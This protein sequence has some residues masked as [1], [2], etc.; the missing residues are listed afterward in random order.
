VI[1]I[2]LYLYKA[3]IDLWFAIISSKRSAQLDDS[4]FVE[5][6]TRYPVRASSQ[7]P[8]KKHGQNPSLASHHHLTSNI[9]LSGRDHGWPSSRDNPDQIQL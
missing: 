9:G 8:H 7:V 6:E 2:E 5:R 1:I 4:T 3:L